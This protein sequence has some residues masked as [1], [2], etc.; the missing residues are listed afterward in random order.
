MDKMITAGEGNALSLTPA[1]SHWERE[2]G[3]QP[4][5][6]LARSIRGTLADFLPLLAGE[7]RGEGERNSLQR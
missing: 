5:C 1:L 2:H 6:H 7:G 3:I 4:H